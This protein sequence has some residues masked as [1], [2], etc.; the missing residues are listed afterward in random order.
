MR[1][2]RVLK[3]RS[4]AEVLRGEGWAKFRSTQD[5]DLF[6]GR[7]ASRWGMMFGRRAFGFLRS[8]D[9]YC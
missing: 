3:I 5:L 8:G 1:G 2:L 6:P 4:Y 9:R 7:T